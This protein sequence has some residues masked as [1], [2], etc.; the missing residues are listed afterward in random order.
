[1][2][3]IGQ[4]DSPFVRRVAIAMALYG[5][6]FEH[7]RWSIFGDADLVARHNPLVRIPALVLD[8]GTV[9]TDS[10]AILDELDDMVGPDRALMPPTP[11]LRR[12]A[13]AVCA[14]G[15]GLADKSVALFYELR[16]HA[17]PAEIWAA[18]LRRQIGAALAALEADRA[19]RATPFWF[20]A[21]ISHADIAVA[22][23]LRFLRDA[24]GPMFDPEE[25]PALAGHLERCEA[26]AVFRDHS[27]PF[28]PPRA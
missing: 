17:A 24:H 1:M 2:I 4:Y 12:Q 27:Q 16:L 21:A 22:C 20:G 6:G 10:W 25:A 11:A 18:R 8:D 23:T 15:T 7:R 19:G 3:L 14:L 9:L 5:I 28:A 13:R 26:L